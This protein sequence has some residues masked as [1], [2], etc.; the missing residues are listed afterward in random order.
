[1]SFNSPFTGNV[2][3]PTDVSYRSITLSANTTLEWPINGNAT[4][5]YAARIMNVTAT[6]GGLVLRMP[7]ANQASVGQDAL[8]RNVGANSFTVADYDGNVI[9]VVAASEAKYIYIT[10]NPDEA[11]TWGVVAFGVGTSAADAG[12]LDGYGLT[13]IGSTLNTAHPVQTFSSNYTV[14]ATDRASTY[15]WTGGAGTLTLP[16]SGVL[17]D[18]WFMLLRNNGTGTLT[19]SPSGG[20][21]IDGAA[22]I[23]LQPADSAIIC[24]SGTAF[25]TVGIGKS[26]DFNF[27]QNTK[28]VVSGAYTLSASEAANPIQKFTGTL[29]GSVTV[30]VPQT[31]AVYYIT[32]QTDGTGAGYTITFTTGVAGSA[33]AVVPAGQQVILL[34]DSSNLYNASTVAAG[35]SNITLDDGSVS[36]PSLSFATELTTGVY[37]P[38]SAEWAVAILGVQRLRLQAS[39][40]TIVGNVSGVN[41]VFSGNVS[42]VNGSFTGPVSGTTGTFSG[43]VS[44]TTG[45]FSGAVSGTTG[46]FTSGV[47]GGTF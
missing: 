20:N 19:V 22:T 2:I 29:S 14:V 4:P 44:G 43:A 27:T 18:N 12:S 10:A 26:A 23:T 38:G 30:T 21:Q 32:N 34:C 11:G 24:C 35:A 39:G 1:M 41:G 28:A 42:G 3:V 17:G 8:I 9:V 25:F 15:V 5:N 45:T 40:L 7:P 13:V 37:R 46:T 33:S 6:A 36:T 47:S 16:S 31:I